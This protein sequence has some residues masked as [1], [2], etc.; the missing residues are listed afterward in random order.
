MSEPI[1]LGL[2]GVGRAG[3]GMHTEELKGKEDLFQFAAACDLLPERRE[4]MAARYN[5]KTYSRIEDL[6][7]D[8]GV[9][10]VDIATRS[11]DHYQH[12]KMALEAGKDVLL[13]KPMCETYEQA[14]K[15]CKISNKPGLPRLF[16]RHNRRFEKVFGMI[17]E[18][19]RTK[20]LGEIYQIQINRNNYSRRNDWQTISKFGGGQL[21]NWG[22][23]IIDQ[24]LCFLN[25]HVQSVSG[26]LKHVVAAGDCEDHVRIHFK[27]ADGMLVDMQISGGAALPTPDY[28]VYGTKGALEATGNQVTLRYIDP[29]QKLNPL[30]ADPGTPGQTFGASGTF[31]AAE[32][33]HWTQETIRFEHEDLSVI[34]NYLYGAY[35]EGKD[36]PISMEEAIAVIRVISEVRRGTEF[37]RR[38]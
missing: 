14:L 9:E 18:L 29:E 25:H 19:I 34:W 32:T 12:A 36:Y 5:C 6:I 16:V 27:G 1:R 24:S 13:E 8:P 38:K 17:L 28:I 15:L 20:K 23:H 21:L 10:L 7:A 35:R 4:K 22:P 31:S 3:W 11:C 26:E 33:I 2:V 37:D 30:T